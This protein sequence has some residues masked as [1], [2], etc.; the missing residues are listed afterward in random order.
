M[1]ELINLLLID[2]NEIVLETLDE[3]FR[4]NNHSIRSVDSIAAAEAVLQ[5]NDVDAIIC[6]Y[7]LKDSNGIELLA[8]LRKTGF[9][10][11]FILISG[12]VTNE[13]I[14]AGLRLG[15][16]EIL[17]KPLNFDVLVQSVLQAINCGI[18]FRTL[19][20]RIKTKIPPEDAQLIL[21]SLRMTSMLRFANYDRLRMLLM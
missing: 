15:A 17:D 7:N 18:Q 14:F 2:D 16:F 19:Q 3:L 8:R 9:Q 12:D 10:T 13:L 11:P 20:E 4:D 5:K 6:D 21:Q 1:R